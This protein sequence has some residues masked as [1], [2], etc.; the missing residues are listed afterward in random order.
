MPVSLEKTLESVRSSRTDKGNR[1]RCDVYS[2]FATRVPVVEL[3]TFS[4]RL[5]LRLA[6]YRSRKSSESA[7]LV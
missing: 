5:P 7:R 3:N 4:G 2:V 1:S 6:G